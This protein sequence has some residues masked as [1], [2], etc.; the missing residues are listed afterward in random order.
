MKVE[1][2]GLLDYL[3]CTFRALGFAGSANQAFFNL[4]GNRLFILDLENF[5]RAGLYACAASSAF[6]VIDY[7]FHHFSSLF[8]WSFMNFKQ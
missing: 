7:N 3:D 1:Y 6:I 2:K 4:H 8:N 5:H